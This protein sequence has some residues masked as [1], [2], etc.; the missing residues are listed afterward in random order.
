MSD[1]KLKAAWQYFRMLIGLILVAAF[2]Y[3]MLTGQGD[4]DIIGKLLM[5]LMGV[6]QMG[7]GF[8][9]ARQVASTNGENGHSQ[10]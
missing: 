4:G 3:M 10:S 6:M 7:S 5:L 1:Q 8:V 9:N 2:V